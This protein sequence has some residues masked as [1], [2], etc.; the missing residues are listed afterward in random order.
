MEWTADFFGFNPHSYSIAIHLFIRLLGVIYIVAYIPFLFQIKGLLGSEGIRP[1]T[2]YLS[3]LKNRLGKKRFYY[4]PTFFWLNAS[5]FALFALVSLGIFLG[6]L[7][8]LGIHPPLLLLLLYLI[9]LSLTAAGQEFLSFGWETFLM[10]ITAAAFLVVAT[11]PLNIFGWIGLNFLL[12]RFH[13]QAGVS[14]LKSRDPNWRNLTAISYHYETQPLPNTIAWYFHKLP[15]GFHKLSTLSMFYIELIV[16][17]A[18]FSPPEMR[19]LVCIQLIALQ[20]FIWLTGNLSFLNHMTVVFCLILLQNRFLV[21][22]F[23]PLPIGPSSHIAWNTCISL[24]A[25]GFLALQIVCFLQTFFPRRLFRRILAKVEPFHL[26]YPHGIFAIMTTERYEIILEG[27]RDGRIWQEY[28]FFFKPGDL[29][30]RPRRISPFQ[31]RIDW[32]AWFLPFDDFENERWFQAFM[33]KLLQGSPAVLSLLKHNPFPENPPLEIRAMMYKYE[34]TSFNERKQTGHWW[35]RR[36][37]GE[38]AP[39]MS[40]KIG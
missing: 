29:S 4:C 8:T 14:K 19:F 11:V 7:L 35:K 3:F 39:P 22:F 15:M 5:D 36:I 40:L 27:S 1:V 30:L 10:E 16:P 2:H 38:Y 31:P 25:I 23:D 26:A 33:F 17:F 12:F 37:I 20:V 21:S 6:V 34:F 28:Q 32:Q 18:I 9:H 13:V 24:L